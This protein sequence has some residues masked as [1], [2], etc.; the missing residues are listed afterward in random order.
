MLSKSKYCLFT[1]C[2]KLLWLNVH[3]PELAPPDPS[4]ASRLDSGNV[5]GD[6]A[7]QLFG[8]FVEV[9]AYKEDGSLDLTKMIEQTGE[10]ICSGENIICEASFSYRGNYCAVDIL[11]KEANG[12][13]IYE[14]KSSTHANPIYAT[15]IAYQKYVLEHCGV[16][17]TGTYLVCINSSYVFD[18][19]FDLQKFFRVIDLSEKVAAEYGKVEAN[20]RE[21]EAVLKLTDEPLCDL[22]ERCNTPYPCAFWKYCSA[23][24]PSPSVFDLYRF[25]IEKSIEYYRQ[26][27][28]SFADLEKDLTV[29]EGI[30]SLQIRHELHDLDTYIDR[31]G[32]KEFLDTLSYPL[33][34]LDFE[35]MQPIVPEFVGTKPYTQIPFQYSLHYIDSPNSELKH[36]EFLGISGEDPR[37]AIAEQLCA[38]I[39]ADVCVLAYNKGFEC[40]RIRELAACFPDLR[41]H[42]L[43]IAGNIKDLI[44][45]FRKGHYYNRAM[46]ASFSIKSVLPAIY[47]DDPSLD[48][49][50][51]EGV[52]NGSEAMDIFP[53]IK[54]MSPED[55]AK[56]RHNLLKYCEL[57]TYAMVKVWEELVR[58]SGESV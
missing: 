27:K 2:P 42:L 36:K 54:D 14:V 4:L 35:T 5:I 25:P 1:Q 3:A 52:H 21:A 47:P 11:R 38:D 12:Y 20:V 13:A 18:G 10:L 6:M 19:T 37:R 28:V 44:D 9:T 41:D 33:Y 34:F 23:H 45:P 29:C 22:S 48:Y 40:G 53:R 46:G 51:L 16:K 24:L 31:S 50:N 26:G 30:R 57:D 43:S 7:M 15:D 32:V 39:P 17:V 55:A 56:A 58:V 49:H 8:N